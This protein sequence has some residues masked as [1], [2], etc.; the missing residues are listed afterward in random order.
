[1]LNSGTLSSFL[2]ASPKSR[3]AV[4]RKVVGAIDLDSCE[5]GRESSSLA[6]A[7]RGFL[8][9]S[10]ISSSTVIAVQ[11]RF[12]SRVRKSYTSLGV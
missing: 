9:G 6:R 3:S 2:I 12:C 7:K 11:L 8:V 1:M 4:S 10:R 5:E